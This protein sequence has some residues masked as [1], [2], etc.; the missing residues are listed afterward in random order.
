MTDSARYVLGVH[1]TA[2]CIWHSDHGYFKVYYMSGECRVALSRGTL[3]MTE[4]WDDAAESLRVKALQQINQCSEGCSVDGNRHDRT[5]GEEA[6]T[7][8]RS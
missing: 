7:E 6:T 1:P 5:V 2:K 4:A 3:S 8:W